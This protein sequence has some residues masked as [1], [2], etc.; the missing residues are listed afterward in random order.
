M[1]YN[2]KRIE[3]LIYDLKNDR[4]LYKKFL[5]IIGSTENIEDK[6]IEFL[7]NIIIDFAKENGYDVSLEDIVENYF[8]NMHFIDGL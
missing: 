1:W 6:S 4:Q 3:E 2:L 7:E 8:T 5:E